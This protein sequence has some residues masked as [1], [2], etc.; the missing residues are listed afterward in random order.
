MCVQRQVH[1]M[2]S[3][4]RSSSAYPESLAQR[5]HGG[6]HAEN[7]NVRCWQLKWLMVFPII[8]LATPTAAGVLGFSRRRK[9]A[10]EVAGAVWTSIR[11]ND[12][13]PDP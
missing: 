8:A 4:A 12:R 11:S 5:Q 7:R 1:A 13:R 2:V 10:N 9:G 3:M 6:G